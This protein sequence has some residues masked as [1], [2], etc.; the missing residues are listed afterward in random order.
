MGR[1]TIMGCQVPGCQ[2]TLLAASLVG[3]L[4]R[5]VIML[6]LNMLMAMIISNVIKS[7]ISLLMT[8]TVLQSS[9]PDGSQVNLIAALG[10]G[11]LLPVVVM[12][13]MKSVI[14]NV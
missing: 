12:N 11:S 2:E 6:M 9:T 1:S 5:S 8:R 13:V 10:V 4:L 3:T 14:L 7:P